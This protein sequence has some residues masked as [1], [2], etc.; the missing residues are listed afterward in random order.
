LFLQATIAIEE[1]KYKSLIIPMLY[2]ATHW[3]PKYR[4]FFLLI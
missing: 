2:L 3:K 4:D 1:S